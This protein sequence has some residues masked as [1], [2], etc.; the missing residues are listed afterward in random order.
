M[1]LDRLWSKKSQVNSRQGV[2]C[3]I[4][5]HDDMLVF[6]CVGGGHTAVGQMLLFSV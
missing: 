5:G 6:V 3:V 1:I 4:G 2:A